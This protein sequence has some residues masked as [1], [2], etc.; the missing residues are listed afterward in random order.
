MI[1]SAIEANVF[2]LR[3]VLLFISS[4]DWCTSSKYVSEVCCG[5]TE[6]GGVGGCIMPGI[7]NME[8]YG[9]S[10]DLEENLKCDLGCLLLNDL[11]YDCT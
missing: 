3:W 6:F 1:M 10:A 9:W 8:K 2:C 7:E 4:I 5:M 11:C